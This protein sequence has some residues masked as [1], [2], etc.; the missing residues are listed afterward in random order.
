MEGL[1]PTLKTALAFWDLTRRLGRDRSVVPRRGVV[2]TGGSTGAAMAASLASNAST[3]VNAMPTP[4]RC[5]RSLGLFA[6]DDHAIVQLL[7]TVA[8]RLLVE[9]RKQSMNK[10]GQ[11]GDR[12]CPAEGEGIT[13]MI[14]IALVDG[15]WMIEKDFPEH[16]DFP[17]GWGAYI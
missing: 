11:R 1:G 17:T 12:Q 3:K 9:K 7:Y 6:V 13:Q 16:F 4:G 15:G 10:A 5:G 2:R 8:C 14:E